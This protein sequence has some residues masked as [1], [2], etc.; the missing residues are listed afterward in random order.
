MKLL[1]LE[2]TG[3]IASVALFEEEEI[4]E[5][6]GD[7]GYNHLTSLIP[8]M[9]N[10]L[11]KRRLDLC[12]LDAVGVSVGPGSF[13][14]IRIGVSTAR[15]LGQATGLPL[16]AVPTLE[17]FCFNGGEDGE[18]LRCPILDARRD[19]VYGACFKG[20]EMLIPTG[21]YSLSNYFSLLEEKNLERNGKKVFWFG[22]GVFRYE[23]KIL[24]WSE[25]KGWES[26]FAPKEVLYQ[27]AASGVK[28]AAQL[29]VENH[30]LSYN[31]LLPEYHRLAEAE[32]KRQ[33]VLSGEG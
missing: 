7:E 31:Q 27:T 20:R 25:S 2:T 22:D 14:G 28:L 19:Q 12:Q 4:T 18:S 5:I 15:A 32:R 6:R 26:C 11:E 13:T 1:A 23:E 9:K 21:P 10:L 8:M 16:I 29:Y 24:S 30:L 33:E 17:T 3:P